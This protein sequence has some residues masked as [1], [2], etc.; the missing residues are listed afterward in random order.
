VLSKKAFAIWQAGEAHPERDNS[1]RHFREIG[2]S[3]FKELEILPLGSIER[4]CRLLPK[5]DFNRRF[6][7][8]AHRVETTLPMPFRRVAARSQ[9]IIYRGPNW[10]AKKLKS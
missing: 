10:Q 2:Q 3:L 4:F 7:R 5:G 8:W 9:L 1:S 6:R